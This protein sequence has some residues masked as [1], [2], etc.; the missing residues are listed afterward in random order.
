M[1]RK[2]KRAQ[3]RARRALDY[4]AML[5][6]DGEGL[7][8][9]PYVDAQAAAAGTVATAE[10]GAN[11]LISVYDVA[12]LAALPVSAT[13]TATGITTRFNIASGQYPAQPPTAT[14]VSTKR[15]FNTHVEPRSGHVCIGDHWREV[16]GKELLAEFTLRMIRAFNFEDPPTNEYGYQ[17]DALLYYRTVL[18]GKPFNP[19][20][21]LPAI[22]DS[23]FELAAPREARPRV[24]IVHGGGTPQP[25]AVRVPDGQAARCVVVDG[26]NP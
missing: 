22:P 25:A 18:R 24:V 3:Q 11:G 14:V 19:D 17:P 12:C 2:G 15:P 4:R 20:L 8:V 21:K 16:G 9:T 6:L 26:G 13:E 10:D 5:S 1:S 7:E 23:V